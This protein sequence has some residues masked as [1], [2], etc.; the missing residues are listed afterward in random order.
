MGISNKPLVGYQGKASTSVF[1]QPDHLLVA[2]SFRLSSGFPHQAIH[3]PQNV[4][5]HGGSHENKEYAHAFKKRMR[6]LL[7]NDRQIFSVK[8]KI[9]EN[10]T[11]LRLN[12]LDGH[13]FYIGSE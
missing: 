8:K 9:V 6:M 7:K 2:H 4:F 12:G 11:Y 10:I 3:L 13:Q 1:V 5:S